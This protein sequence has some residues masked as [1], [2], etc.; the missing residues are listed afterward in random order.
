MNKRDSVVVA[1]THFFTSSSSHIWKIYSTV[2]G[3]VFIAT[4]VSKRTASE[5]PVKA[6]V[7]IHW[8]AHT[9]LGR[10][11]SRVD[12]SGSTVGTDRK[13]NKERVRKGGEIH[14]N[15]LASIHCRQQMVL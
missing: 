2:L 1:I 8:S 11:S 10:G 7:A 6:L 5:A 15:T 13:K 3:N 14:F 12:C 4:L 9:F